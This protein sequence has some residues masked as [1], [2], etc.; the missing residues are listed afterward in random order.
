[1]N[2]KIAIEQIAALERQVDVSELRYKGLALW[3][4]VRLKLWNWMLHPEEVIPRPPSGLQQVASALKE[5]FFNPGFYKA[6][7]T[8]NRQHKQHLVNLTAKGPIDILFFSRVEDHADWLED[9]HYNRHIDPLI[10]DTGSRFRTLKLELLTSRTQSTLPRS[11]PTCFID[12]VDFVR[13]DAQRSLITAF[14]QPDENVLTG[15]E[16]LL[17]ALNNT[18]FAQGINRELLQIEGERLCHYIQYFVEIL[19][20]LQPKV[21]FQVC[22]YYDIAMA[23][24]AACRKL[25]I[26][27]VDIQHGKQGKYHGSYTHWCRVPDAGFELLPDYFWCWG[28]ASVAH[29]KK[30]LPAGNERHQAIVGGNRW[31]AK[32]KVNG[33]QNEPGEAHTLLGSLKEYDKVILVSLQPLV[34]LLPEALLEAMEQA[35]VSWKWLIRLH[36]RDRQKISELREKLNALDLERVEVEASTTLPL[37]ALLR[38]ATHHVTQWSSVC[39]E[40]LQFKVPSVIIHPAGRS[41]FSEYIEKGH[42]LYAESAR[43]ILKALD[44]PVD[45]Y[46]EETE[47]YIVVDTE[48]AERSLSQILPTVARAG[49]KWPAVFT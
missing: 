44:K 10:D 11:K 16:G 37:Y 3:P 1:M 7:L 38:C 34:D 18:P 14:Q 2:H 43:G 31:L 17:D 4:M 33:H 28:E 5:G 26:Q 32:W 30:W 41:L 36:P 9:G 27:T 40:A 46:P 42:F 45:S 25:G 8:H 39:Y 6:Y 23:L 12:A 24:N 22:Y 49:D 13:A 20:V 48:V 47:P 21:V 29:I 19:S 35:P 15:A